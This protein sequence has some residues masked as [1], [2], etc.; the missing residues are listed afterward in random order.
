MRPKDEV[1]SAHFSGKK[2]T[3]YCAIVEP[4]EYQFHYHVS[5]DTKHDPFLVDDVK[6]D[7]KNEDLWI[8]S[9]NALSLYKNKHAYRFYQRLAEEFGL[10]IIRTYG[11]SGHGKV[12]IDA[13]L[14]FGAKNILR[15]D[16]TTQDEVTTAKVLTAKLLHQRSPL[17]IKDC[18][19][20]RMMIY[21]SGKSVVPVRFMSKIVVRKLR[22][23]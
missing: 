5:N 4:A 18:I 2:F 22:K 8:R 14:S 21:E 10:R 13:M 7:I 12:I 16:I 15:H 3:L 17:E 23:R 6:Y 20:E 1:Q 11:A 9:N 19:K